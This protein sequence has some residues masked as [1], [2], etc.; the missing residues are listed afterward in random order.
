MNNSKNFTLNKIRDLGS[1]PN[2]VGKHKNR[3]KTN[4]FR[5]YGFK[6]NYAT[7]LN[8][9]STFD[10]NLRHVCYPLRLQRILERVK[11]HFVSQ[12]MTWRVRRC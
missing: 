10:F 1:N 7:L 3:P 6:M 5:K 4:Y 12:V 8:S 9:E 11:H 2:R